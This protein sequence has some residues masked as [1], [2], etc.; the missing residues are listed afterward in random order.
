M[1]TAM[2]TTEIDRDAVL[3]AEIDRYV[4]RGYRVVSQTPRT[5]QL[6]RPKR[7]ALLPF[8]VAAGVFVVL[9]LTAVATASYVWAG[10]GLIPLVL[11]ARRGDKAA[12]LRVDEDGRVRRT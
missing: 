4:R 7:F 6:V 1:A 10:V 2:G 11:Y 5:A 9:L 8:L 12:Y 3:Q